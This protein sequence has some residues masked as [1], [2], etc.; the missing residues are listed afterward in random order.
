[1]A[2]NIGLWQLASNT[3]GS[4]FIGTQTAPM[5]FVVSGTFDGGSVALESSVDDTN[6]N[7]IGAVTVVGVLDGRIFGSQGEKFRVT[8]SGG[9]AS[10]DIIARLI[11]LAA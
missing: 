6:W 7:T 2:K 1:M 4:S 3:T 10:I 9:G 8:T 11:E 5:Q